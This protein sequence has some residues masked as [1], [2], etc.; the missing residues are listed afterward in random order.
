[1]VTVGWVAPVSGGR[2]THLDAE[3]SARMVDVGGKEPSERVARA[4][5][6]VRMSPA[7]AEIVSQGSGPKG[8]VLAVARLAGIQA[9]KQTAHLIPLAH[10]LALTF[11]DVRASV[12]VPEGLVEI[13]AEVRTHARTGVE[14]EVMTACAVAALTVYDMVK[15]LERGIELEQVVLLEKR[16]GSSDYVREQEHPPAAEEVSPPA[17]AGGAG[18][19]A[20]IIT[21]STSKARGEGVDESGPLLGELVRSLGGEVLAAELISDDRG[22]IEARLRHW[23]DVERCGLVLTSGGTGVAPSD[24]TPE[25]TRSVLDREIPGLAEAM[26]AASRAHTPFWALSRGLA[27]LRGSTLIVNFPGSPRSIQETGPALAEAIRHALALSACRDAG[28]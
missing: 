2:L 20:A 18:P 6:R 7:A 11:I 14:M 27:G 17:A 4:R 3:G 12:A 16:G 25:A 13:L 19:S 28:H 9:A 23:C 26:R 5:A 21:I 8:E 15:G 22:E 1:M 24:V 10:P